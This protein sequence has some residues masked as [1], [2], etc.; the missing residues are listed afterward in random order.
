MVLVDDI[1]KESFKFRRDFEQISK[2]LPCIK[3][4]TCLPLLRVQKEKKE[5]NDGEM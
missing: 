4:Y 2:N 1:V 3:N 5:K